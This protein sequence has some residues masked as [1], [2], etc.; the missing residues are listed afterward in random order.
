MRF[1]YS[2]RKMAKLFGNSGDP[3]QMP[4][5]AAS[6]LG[7]PCLQITLLWV[8]RLFVPTFSPERLKLT[9]ALPESMEGRE[10]L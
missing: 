2:S 5:S 10:L 6:D 9:T 7:L 3:D 8:S 4:H 1:R